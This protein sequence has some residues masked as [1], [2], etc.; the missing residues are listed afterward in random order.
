MHFPS[1]GLCRFLGFIH[2]SLF[3]TLQPVEK[4][5]RERPLSNIFNFYVLLSVLLQFALHIGSMVYITELA[6]GLEEYVMDLLRCGY[7]ADI[8]V[9]RGPIDL[10]AKFEANLLNT[11]VFLL[12][13]SQQ[14]ST[15]AINFQV[16]L[17][18]VDFQRTLTFSCRDG[19]FVKAFGRTVL[20]IGV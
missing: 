15:F 6:H 4:L 16:S 20:C 9:S 18:Q 3:L 1:E 14:V 7:D 17:D 2:V 5:S 12:G 13:L 8:L 10:E 11:A 19:H